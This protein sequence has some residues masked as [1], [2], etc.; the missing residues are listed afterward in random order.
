LQLIQLQ[1][2]HIAAFKLQGI[3][4]KKLAAVRERMHKK[5]ME[6]EELKELRKR[7]AARMSDAQK[8][9][10]F[11]L[12]ESIGEETQK[13]LNRK[14]LLRPNTKFAV[15][16]KLLFVICILLDIV[17]LAIRPIVRDGGF[18]A[19]TLALTNDRCENNLKQQEPSSHKPHLKADHWY[20]KEPMASL[21][22]KL[23]DFLALALSPAPITDREECQTKKKNILD[24][25][26]KRQSPNEGAIRWYC[27]PSATRMQSIYRHTFHWIFEQFFV[28]VDIICWLDVPITFLIGELDEESGVLIPKPFFKRWIAPGLALQLLVNPNMES[29]SHMLEK[30]IRATAELGPFRVFRWFVAVVFPSVFLSFGIVLQCVWIPLVEEQNHMNTQETFDVYDDSQWLVD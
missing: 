26:L 2:E 11:E 25:L 12:Q 7:N 23:H 30:F 17:Q 5:K 18:L 14:L 20:C 4:R 13:L 29:V 10:L 3:L 8:T 6:L 24:R 19:D 28:F 1:R 27:E 9:R 21:N 22:D 15:Y 16:W